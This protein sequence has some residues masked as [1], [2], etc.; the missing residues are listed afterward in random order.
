ML[1]NE[2]FL[3]ISLFSI[4]G[5]YVISSSGL[6]F[7]DFVVSN[8]KVDRNPN[9]IIHNPANNDLYV[10][11][12]DLALRE[13]RTISVIDGQNNT[14]IDTIIFYDNRGN[15]I[16]PATMAYNS[17]NENLYIGKSGEVSVINRN[18]TA[19]ANISIN[20]PSKQLFGLPNAVAYNSFNDDMYVS[21]TTIFQ[22]QTHRLDCT[23]TTSFPCYVS[24]IDGQNNTVIDTIPVGDL[25]TGIAVNEKNGN[26]YVI[27]QYSKTVSVIDGQNNTV[28]D[29]IPVGAFPNSNPTAIAYNPD[30][31]KIY[32]SG[33]FSNTVFIID[34]QNNTVIDTISLPLDKTSDALI[35]R[36]IYNPNNADMYVTVRDF[37]NLFVIDGQNNTV[38]D[39]I[40]VGKGGASA[41]VYNPENGNMYTTNFKNNTVTVIS[42]TAKN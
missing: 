9:V 1:K 29:T 36:I 42:T 16:L 38:I 12:Q 19:V 4:L 40:P 26:I 28:I 8:I 18:N 10:I 11:N 6:I 32:I 37:D 13:N 2:F 23:E 27:N 33:G 24:V 31:G 14:V 39:T 22:N 34:G 35:G 30:N 21:I 7:A 5:I 15:T 17:E 20:N 25:P 41:I 3:K